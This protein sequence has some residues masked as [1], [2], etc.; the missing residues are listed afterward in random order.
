M[1]S[2]NAAKAGMPVNEWLARPDSQRG[3]RRPKAEPSLKQCAWCLQLHSGQSTYCS[4]KCADDRQSQRN[5]R[6]TQI[7]EGKRFRLSFESGDW[8]AFLEEVKLRSSVN[9]DGCWIWER[10]LKGGYP[11]HKFGKKQVQVHRLSLEAKHGKPLGTQAAHHICSNSACVNPDHLQPV[12]FRDNTAEM[13]QRKAYLDR[14]AE[15]EA[16]LADVSP[17]HPALNVIEV[18]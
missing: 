5:K 6:I 14:I 16:A 3:R 4:E 7:E 15:L 17:G 12:T 18:A 2:I 13:L 9:A 8:I 11:V 10:R 1:D